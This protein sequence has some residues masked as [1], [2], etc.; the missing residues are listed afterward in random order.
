[1]N[2]K[3]CKSLHKF[4]RFNTRTVNIGGV[5]LGGTN[6]IRLQSMTKQIL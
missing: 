6:P 5:P 1:M 2:Y 3:Y 4:N